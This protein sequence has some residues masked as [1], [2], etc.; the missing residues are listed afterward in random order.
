MVDEVKKNYLKKIIVSYGKEKRFEPTYWTSLD[1]SNMSILFLIR[2][3]LE[4]T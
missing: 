3:L 1:R 4:H 2:S